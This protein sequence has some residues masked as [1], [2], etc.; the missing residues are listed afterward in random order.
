MAHIFCK[1]EDMMKE[2]HKIYG[3]TQDVKT[4]Q[5]MIVLDYYYDKRNEEYGIC[6][7]CKRNI[8]NP[9]WCQ[10]CDPSKESTRNS[11]LNDNDEINNCIKSFQFKAVEYD[12]FIEWIQYND[13]AET[14]KKIEWI[15]MDGKSLQEI[16][17]K[18]EQLDFFMASWNIRKIEN[19]PG[20]Y[21]RSRSESRVDLIKLLNSQATRCGFYKERG[22]GT[23]Y[24]AIWLDGKRTVEKVDDCYKRSRRLPYVVALKTFPGSKT[25]VSS[26]LKEFKSHMKCRLEGAELEMYGLTQNTKN[27]DYLMVFQ[28]ANKGNLRKFLRENFN[29]LTWQKKL[30]QLEYMS[31]DLHQIHNAK[32]THCD[33]YSGN[34]LLN[35]NLDG[36]IKSYIADLGLSRKIGDDSEDEVH[37]VMQYVAPEVL[38]GKQP[39]EK[40]DIYGFS[41]IMAEVAGIS[42]FDG[43]EVNTKLAVKICN[44]SQ[45]EFAPK[46]PD[47]YIEWAHKCMDQDPANRPSALVINENINDWL[48]KLASD[49]ENEIK[50]QFLSADETIKKLSIVPQICSH[51]TKKINKQEI[52]KGIYLRNYLK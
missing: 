1:L 9:V 28:Y 2:N 29:E 3:I 31:N 20:V 42:P 26:V 51:H 38:L 30:Q 50:K 33:F 17:E 34:I 21:M 44:G 46:T 15:P 49:D 24:S 22:F 32:F 45:P 41:V 12:N 47:C 19:E 16:E 40:A 36:K 5:Y 10:S 14:I 39:S 4:E 43:H 7:Q 6:E 18:S 23:V 37:G 11:P 52:L 13:L 8:T 48:K 27:N 35:Q 25:D